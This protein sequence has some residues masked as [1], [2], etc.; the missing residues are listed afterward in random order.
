MNVV[1]A[2]LNVV[3]QVSEGTDPLSRYLTVGGALS[4]AIVAALV[5]IRIQRTSVVDLRAD[6]E[7]DRAEIEQL[8]A[9]RERDR[10]EME[11]LRE[12]FRMAAA[13]ARECRAARAGDRARIEALEHECADLYARLATLPPERG[14]T[15][16]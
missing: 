9:D 4:V 7:A 10:Q 8:R 6:R 15:N 2:L 12:D 5:V 14:G 13:E 16:Q 1:A 3:A 11:S